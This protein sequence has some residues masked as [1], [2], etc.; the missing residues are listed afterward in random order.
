MMGKAQ[1]QFAQLFSR[2]KMNRSYTTRKVRKED[3]AALFPRL[4][5]D[6]RVRE[7]DFL[8]GIAQGRWGIRGAVNVYNNSVKNED[9]SYDGLYKMAVNMGVGLI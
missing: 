8:L 1:A 4:A 6:K 5:Q 7:L 9:I 2:I 3:V